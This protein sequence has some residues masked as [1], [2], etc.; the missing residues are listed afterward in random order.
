MKRA[1]SREDEDTRW[2]PGTVVWLQ[3]SRYEIESSR[4]AEP[5]GR[6]M[7]SCYVPDIAELQR[8]DVE[9]LGSRKSGKYRPASQDDRIVDD[10]IFGTFL[11]NLSTR[12]QS[13]VLVENRLALAQKS[14][15]P[16][17]LAAVL[18][19]APDE[20]T[21]PLSVRAQSSAVEH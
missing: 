12:E 15:R 20:S 3:R 6:P 17:G 14:V 8:A 18:V 19:G 21:R 4:C 1:H 7:G 13:V 9:S 5:D 10:E 11:H 16:I 2:I